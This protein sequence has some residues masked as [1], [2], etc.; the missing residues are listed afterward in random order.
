MGAAEAFWAWFV[1]NEKRFRDVETPQKE[2]FLDELQRHLHAFCDSLWFEIGGHPNGPRELIVSAE[3]RSEL[4]PKVRELI[5]AAP[6]LDGWCFIP[7]K[8]AQGFDFVTEYAGLT[9]S[10]KATWFMPLESRTNPAALGLRVAYS[11]FEKSKEKIYLAATYLVLE[12]GLG[13][14]DA[15]ETIQHVE[16]CAAPSA[17]ESAG[18]I[19]LHEL[20][21][22]IRWREKQDGA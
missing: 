15:A 10:P 7:F 12:A 2:Q 18:F 5:G 3:G 20:P 9:I 1:E 21:Q 11:H 6:K 13:E 17:P 14:L 16:V 4:F 19:L 22:Y 8:P